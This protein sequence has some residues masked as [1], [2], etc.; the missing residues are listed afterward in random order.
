M[1]QEA[2]PAGGDFDADVWTAMGDC[3]HGT[4]AS[5]DVTRGKSRKG[6]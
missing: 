5:S 2:V 1:A 6:T 4:W 3:S